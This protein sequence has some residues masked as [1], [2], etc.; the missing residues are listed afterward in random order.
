MTKKASIA[1]VI[2]L[3][4]LA[5]KALDNLIADIKTRGES[6]AR[7]THIAACSVLLHV[8]KHSDIRM[9]TRLLDAVHATTRKNALMAW[10][11]H[12]GQVTFGAKG[13]CTFVADK[14]TMLGEA[15]AKP[16][17]QFSPEPA[18]K[19][20]DIGTFIDS[21]VKKLKTDTDKTKRDH[22]DL[23]N[24]L[25]TFGRPVLVPPMAEIVSHA[26]PLLN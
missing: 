16:F 7:D 3:K 5:G 18:Y 12:Y 4:T 15:M 14:A 9:V 2:K 13:E 17:W 10:F 21:M 23:I 19:P 20:L 6:L 26:D 8:G 25:N 1:P 11:E 22:A 24:H